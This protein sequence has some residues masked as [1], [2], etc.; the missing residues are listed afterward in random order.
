M[1]GWV[2]N[3]GFIMGV[4]LLGR[5]SR[6]GFLSCVM[7]NACYAGRASFDSDYSLLFLSLFLIGLN[8]RSFSKWGKV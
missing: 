4:I 5:K 1:I 2:G 8:L 6:L 7:G 3:V